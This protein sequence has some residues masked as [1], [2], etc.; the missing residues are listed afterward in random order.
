MLEEID[1]F[2]GF[3]I[4]CE[5]ED[6][7]PRLRLWKFSGD[8][9]KRARRR[10]RLPRASLQRPSPHQP[11]LRNASFRYAYQSLVTPSS[12]YEYDSRPAH[13]RC[14]S[15]WKFPAA[16]TALSTPASAS[17]PPRPTAPGSRL[18][19]LSQGQAARRARTRSTFMATVL[20]LLA[21]ARLQLQPAQPARPR[22]G[23]GLRAHP[24]RRRPGQALARRRQDAGQAQHLHRFHCLPSSI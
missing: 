16:S 18:A 14:S 13:P 2:A 12:V 19:R 3:F 11:H 7:L 22:H 6:G 23:D 21:A 9:L 10:D 24:R 20:R 17:T 1:L 5:R 15:R 8:G 4:A